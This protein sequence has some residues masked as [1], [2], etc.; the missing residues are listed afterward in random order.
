MDSGNSFTELDLA[1]FRAGDEMSDDPAKA[2]DIIDEAHRPTS[3]W[4][5]I[6]SALKR[7]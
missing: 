1:F 3:L 7:D 2:T 6:V 5:R 4:A